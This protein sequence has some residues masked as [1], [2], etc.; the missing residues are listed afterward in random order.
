MLVENIDVTNAWINGTIG[1]VH[2]IHEEYVVIR[3][4]SDQFAT[5]TRPVVR[6]VYKSCHG[7]TQIPLTPSFA[8][9]RILSL[10]IASSG[11]GAITSKIGSEHPTRG[12]RYHALNTSNIT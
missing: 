7:R 10:D 6:Y 9:A 4:N 5:T 12:S 3:R 11:S 8:A 2:A 1:T